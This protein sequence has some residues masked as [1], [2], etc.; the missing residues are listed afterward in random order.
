MELPS[1]WHAWIP[2]SHHNNSKLM[3]II[4]DFLA[5]REEPLYSSGLF[6]RLLYIWGHAYEF[7]NNDNWERIEEIC[8]KLSGK[9]D[10][11][12]ATNMEIYEYV[13]AYHSLVYS[14]DEKKVYNPSLHTVWFNVDGRDGKTYVIKSGETLRIG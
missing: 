11:W 8:Q 2:T 12:Y 3:G 9:D 5:L 14:A 10:V 4:D 6:P 1:D 13:E 7:D